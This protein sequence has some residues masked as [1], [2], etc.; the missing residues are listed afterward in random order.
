[1]SE[2]PLSWIGL[3]PPAVD[4]AN[5]V[6]ASP[7]GPL[8]LLATED[9]LRAWI[10]A[11]RPA[12]ALADAASGRLDEVRA[13]REPIREILTAACSGR[14]LPAAAVGAI[15]DAAA[16]VATYPRLLPDGTSELV[17]AG[18][19]VFARFRAAVAR[20]LVTLLSGEDRARL[21]MCGAPSCGMFF[22]RDDRRQRWCT[23]S[24][25][26]RARVARHAVRT[27]RS[28]A[29]APRRGQP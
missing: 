8:D 9:A 10:E 19:D 27:S 29:P 13:L 23:P 12:F 6:I 1:M 7:T 20:S 15:N 4:L 25:G 2:Q 11:E 16:A 14:I 22:L 26:N 28:G 24:C 5:T 17:E 18:A 3:F 21:S